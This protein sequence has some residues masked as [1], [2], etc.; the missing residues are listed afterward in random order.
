MLD[1]GA[2][3]GGVF[4]GIKPSFILGCDTFGGEHAIHADMVRCERDGPF[5]S[6]GVHCTLGRGVS[7]R[8]ALAG[9]GDLG[10]DVDD[11]SLV[12]DEFLSA[13]MCEGVNVRKIKVHGG[14]E[15]FRSGLKILAVVVA[16]IIDKDINTAVGG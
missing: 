2:G 6:E 8:L 11:G 4:E 9:G 14:H 16:G 13:E 15:F 10:A 1:G 12:A 7:G 3:A 5:A